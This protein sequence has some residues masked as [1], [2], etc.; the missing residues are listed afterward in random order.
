MNDNRMVS[1]W[2]CPKCGRIVHGPHICEPEPTVRIYTGPMDIWVQEVC[3]AVP[4]GAALVFVK[5][6]GRHLLNVYCRPAKDDRENGGPVDDT[7]PV[8]AYH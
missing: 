1:N 2:N 6:V 8:R 4:K 3:D 7:F 5:R